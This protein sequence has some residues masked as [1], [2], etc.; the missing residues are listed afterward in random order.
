MR[1]SVIL[2][3]LL[4]GAILLL[5]APLIAPAERV[6]AG[7]GQELQN[8]EVLAPETRLADARRIMMEYNEALGVRCRDC[9]NPKD[10]ASDEKP[11]K[12]VAREMMKMQ[13]DINARWFPAEHDPKVSCWTCHQGQRIPPPVPP[14]DEPA[15]GVTD[16]E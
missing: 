5:G 4:L 2:T 9:H 8:V 11:L 12:I 13:N 6:D 1:R 15:S 16:R 3:T 14:V 7:A 10:F